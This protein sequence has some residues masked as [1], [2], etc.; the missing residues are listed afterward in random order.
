MENRYVFIDK[1]LHVIRKKLSNKLPK[2]APLKEMI[3][4]TKKLLKDIHDLK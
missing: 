1:T 4:I 3:K 2:E